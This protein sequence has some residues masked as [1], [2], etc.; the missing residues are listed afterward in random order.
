MAALA[1]LACLR[2]SEL[3]RLQV[4][5]LWFDYLTDWG[6]PGYEGTCA[7]HVCNR[8]NDAERK[9]HHPVL[10]RSMDPQ[11]DIVVQL[12]AWMRWMGL[13]VHS[14][15]EKRR[16]P[17][18]RCP[19]CPPLFPT[20]QKGPGGATVATQKACSPSRASDCIKEVVSAAG[21]SSKRFSG[22]SARKGGISTAIDAGVPEAILFLQSGHGQ[23][24]AARNYMQLGDPRR[25]LETF[26]AFGL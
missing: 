12:L 24:K 11:L 17:A 1:T 8:K 3:A 7:V 20:T 16:R 4:C 14:R 10:G 6:L 22:V 26:E 25:L 18:A 19:L 21:C 5:D 13:E 15:C 9:G 23:A 2:V